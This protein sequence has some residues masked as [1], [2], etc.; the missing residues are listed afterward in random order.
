MTLKQFYDAIGGNYE[1][2]VARLFS[3]QIV[4]KFLFKFLNDGSYDTLVKS[5]AEGD[6]EIAFR[7]AHTIKGVCQN[8]SFDKLLVSSSALTE[9][10][11]NGRSEEYAPLAEKVKSDYEQTIEKLKELQQEEN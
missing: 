2:V 8:L 4:K 11:R 1:D 3:E 6:Y 10:L 7:S 5:L 9:A